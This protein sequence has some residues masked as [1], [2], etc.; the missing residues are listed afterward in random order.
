MY[1]NQIKFF[2]SC[3]LLSLSLGQVDY[4]SEIQPIFNLSC[5]SCHGSFGG[6]S[7]SSYANLMTGDSENGPVIIPGNHE[8]SLLW[9]KVNSGAM[10]SGNNPNLTS[11]EINL[12][13][14]W[15]D[16]GAFEDP[17]SSTGCTDSQAYNCADDDDWFNYIV[18]IGD[19]MYDNSCNWDWNTST[20][21]PDDVGGCEYQPNDLPD[22]FVN[23]D[24]CQGYYNP[25]A[26]IDD[27]SCRYYQAPHEEDVLFEV[28]E[29]GISL[30]WSAFNAPDNAI[31]ESYHIPV[32]YTHLTLPTNR[33]V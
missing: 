13:A 15:I 2:L 7:L 25:G 22:G 28:A 5:T 32:S 9:Q 11:V 16:E 24:H 23:P 3:C 8:S 31:L 6:L 21:Q 27:G 18:D 12:I 26:S 1:T 19:I 33:E 17:V 29:I 4:N 10:P 30:D 20:N 14:A